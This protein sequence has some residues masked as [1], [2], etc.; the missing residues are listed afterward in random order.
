MVLEYLLLDIIDGVLT[1]LLR[2]A[3]ECFVIVSGM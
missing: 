2:V 1:H 3:P